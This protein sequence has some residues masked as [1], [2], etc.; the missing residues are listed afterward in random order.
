MAW[1][2]PISAPPY[3]RS[4]SWCPLASKLGIHAVGIQ[5]DGIASKQT[6]SPTVRHF[7]RL[8]EA[9]AFST[10]CLIKRHRR[11]CPNASQLTRSHSGPDL[12][13]VRAARQPCLLISSGSG[14]SRTGG[15]VAR[16]ALEE[17]RLARDRRHHRGLEGLRDQEGRFRP[18]PGQEP[19]RVGGDEDHR[20]LENLQELIDGVET[21][22]AVGELDIREDQ[23]RASCSWQGRPRRSGCEQRRSHCD[24]G[25]S[26][27]FRDPSR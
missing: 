12:D 13:E 1:L 3:Y 24:R 21:G 7:V 6:S 27:G 20:H 25:S 8:L 18:L 11:P 2:R 14:S 9:F 19:L 23:A 22:A 15:A 4:S 17:Q 10:S 16:I 26:P 5:A